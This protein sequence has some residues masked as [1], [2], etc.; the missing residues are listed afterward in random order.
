MVRRLASRVAMLSAAIVAAP[1][2]VDPPDR[3]IVHEWGTF[4][5]IA[6]AD[7][8]AVEWT[9][10]A[11]PSDL[12][13]FVRRHR[14]NIKGNLRGTVRMETPVLY[15]YAPTET[16]V[17]VRVRFNGGLITEWFPPA[18]VTPAQAVD[19][20]R[21]TGTITW[22]NVAVAPDVAADFRTEPGAS[23]YY[24]ARDTDADPLVSGASRERFLFY[25]GI[26][27]FA[28]PIAAT[29]AGDGSVAVTS[30]ANRALGDIM[31]F[32]NRGG[33]IAVDIRR[34]DGS[35][36]VLAPQAPQPG[37][38]LPLADL[39][40]ILVAHG[41]YEKEAH[42]MVETWRDSW[43][44]EGARLIYVVPS[45]VVDSILPLDISPVPA[46]VSRAF[47]GRIELV[48]PAT[49]R[50]VGDA[51]AAGDDEVLARYARFLEP[52]LHRLG[53][54]RAPSAEVVDACR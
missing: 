26:G 8:R 47:V 25:R 23:H 17:T 12:P 15:F 4:T 34:I 19:P 44:E 1:H 6:G 37:T 41:L 5:S 20:Q 30:T 11:G 38:A 45:E 9:P 29:V 50:D 27:T 32:E 3:A 18:V 42:A 53:R 24:R 43:F 52:I 36:A 33:S 2:A 14:F 49:L 51:L 40:R 35:E 31:L 16:R 46:S 13:C 48:T 54:P 7:G 21:M 28:P 22:A 10:Q 39:E